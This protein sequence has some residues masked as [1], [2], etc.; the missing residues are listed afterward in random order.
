MLIQRRL[1]PPPD[2]K[3][4]RRIKALERMWN[5]S[6]LPP[7]DFARSITQKHVTKA[8][9]ASVRTMES[10]SGTGFAGMGPPWKPS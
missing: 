3:I 6:S 8:E 7:D 5:V 9:Q 2:S 10:G 4:A 1:S